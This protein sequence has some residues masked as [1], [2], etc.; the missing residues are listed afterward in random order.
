MWN[1]LISAF[2]GI[3]LMHYGSFWKAKFLAKAQGDHT[4]LIENMV[5]KN[6]SRFLIAVLL[7]ILTCRH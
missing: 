4:P 1:W 6:Y 3:Y 7:T 5:K 2:H